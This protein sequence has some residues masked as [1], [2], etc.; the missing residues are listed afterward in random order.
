MEQSFI[1]A[2]SYKELTK[3]Q[4]RIADYITKNQKRILGMTALEIGREIGVSDASVIRFARAIG[5]DGFSDMKDS[6]RQDIREKSEKIGRHSLYDRFVLQ[7]EKYNTGQGAENEI[8]QLMGMNLETSL[9]QNSM[10]SYRR[11]ADQILKANRKVVIGLRGGKGCA[12]QFA[13]LLG[14]FTGKVSFIIEEGH[15]QIAKLTELGEEDVVI[16]LNFPRYYRIDEKLADILVKQKV[17][18]YL[19]TD[20]MESPVAKW[21]E[22]VLLVETE[23]CGFFHSM[24]GVEGVLEYLLILMCWKEPETFREKLKERDSVLEEYRV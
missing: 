24:L 17:P 2:L 23:H 6:I 9:R 7:T 16:F 22:E 10:E 12:T 3:G 11:I 5:Y 21:A 13:R 18:Y 8:F 1:K 4:A 14:H 15:D 19:I 20:S